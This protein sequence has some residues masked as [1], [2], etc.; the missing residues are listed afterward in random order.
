MERKAKVV[1]CGACLCGA[2]WSGLAGCGSARP[3]KYYQVNYAA[4]GTVSSAAPA[5]DISLL[6]KRFQ[7]PDMYRDDRIVR[8][9]DGK[10]MSKLEASR[11]AETPADMLQTALIHG[12]QAGGKYHM[13]STLRS[14]TKGEYVLSGQILEF[15]EISGGSPA[16]RL[17]YDVD[18][19]DSATGAVLW[20][21][22]YS[23]D[24]PSTG[25]DVSD[26]VSAMQKNIDRSVQEIDA[27]IGAYL[28]AHAKK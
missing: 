25:K 26:F 20:T 5:Y 7:T 6:V 15:T 10:Y 22:S 3:A 4:G 11:W 2:L 18:L 28:S 16:A 13:V 21:K 12:L 9:V 19:K 27:G 8:S 14:G 1:M 24:E 23:Y 17:R